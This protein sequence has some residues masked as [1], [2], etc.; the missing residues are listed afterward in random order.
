MQPSFLDES[1]HE[2]SEHVEWEIDGDHLRLTMTSPCIQHSVYNSRPNQHFLTLMYWCC[3]VPVS[4]QFGHSLDRQC[5][6]AQ[7]DT[8]G[9]LG[10]PS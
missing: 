1:L 4:R 3:G 2:L 6:E 8:M 5:Y 7:M 10:I 9:Q